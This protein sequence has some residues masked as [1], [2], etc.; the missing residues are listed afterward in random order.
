MF[1]QE[2]DALRS[3]GFA[4]EVEHLAALVQVAEAALQGLPVERD[5]V[6]KRRQ[7]GALQQCAVD[8][9]GGGLE[10]LLPQFTQFTGGQQAFGVEADGG[11]LKVLVVAAGVEVGGGNFVGRVAARRVRWIPMLR[12]SRVRASPRFVA[13]MF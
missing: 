11:F 7:F 12:R 8:A 9:F 5:F 1:E 13:A 4:V 10:I 3:V 2:G 6:S